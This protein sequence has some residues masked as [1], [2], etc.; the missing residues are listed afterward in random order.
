MGATSSK[1]RYKVNDSSHDTSYLLDQFVSNQLLFEMY[2]NA[3][4]DYMQQAEENN[5]AH[6]NYQ[7]GNFYHHGLGYKC[8]KDLEK[9]YQY[10]EKAIEQEHPTAMYM[11]CKLFGSDKRKN[12]QDCVKL[13]N[14]KKLINMKARYYIRS[15]AQDPYYSMA[16]EEL[17]Y[18]YVYSP[19]WRREIKEIFSSY[20]NI[21]KN[22]NQSSKEELARIYNELG[23]LA[24]R[25]NANEDQAVFRKAFDFFKRAAELGNPAGYFNIGG[26]LYYNGFGV[27]KDESKKLEYYK[28]AAHD[29]HPRAL[30]IVAN[31]YHFSYL[32]SRNDELENALDLFLS[33]SQYGFAE[34]LYF[35][36]EFFLYGRG[37]VK[38]DYE[39]AR[40]Y[41]ERAAVAT[42]FTTGRGNAWSNYVLGYMYEKGHGVECDYNKAAHHYALSAKKEY[43]VAYCRLAKLVEKR[44][45]KTSDLYTA[46]ELYQAAVDSDD[47]FAVCYALY[48]LGKIYGIPDS[49]FYD[50][51]KATSYLR[52]AQANQLYAVKIQDTAVVGQLY[53]SGVMYEKGLGVSP[54]RELAI[55]YYQKAAELSKQSYNMFERYN[56]GKAQKCFDRLAFRGTADAEEANEEENI[57]HHIKENLEQA[58]ITNASDDEQQ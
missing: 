55:K 53:R 32:E 56:G 46:V 31:N 19:V 36:G 49:G 58:E 15:A 3:T 20:R 26:W 35:I 47:D 21:V 11:I 18:H 25:L 8:N 37:G 42:D 4:L 17:G 48:R 54:N 30:Y 1:G 24:V 14:E 13:M 9:A 27:D 39:K 29:G 40:D 33:A 38:Q 28:K 16:H 45:L 50:R 5:D 51:A 6:A 41:F 34:I 22:S 2:D 52:A 43:Y 12:S 57:E 23:Y 44:K 10:Y 7:L